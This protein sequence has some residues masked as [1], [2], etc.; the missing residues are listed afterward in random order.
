MQ[1]DYDVAIVGGGMVGAS[2]AC[3][4][5]STNLSIALIETSVLEEDRQPSYDERGI[6][7]SRTRYSTRSRI[8]SA[9]S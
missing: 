7:L 3:A 9:D 2:F 1:H 5:A 6:S 4:I 8:L